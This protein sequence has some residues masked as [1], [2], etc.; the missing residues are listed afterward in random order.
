MDQIPRAIKKRADLN[1]EET[2]R[3]AYMSKR[4]IKISLI[5]F[6]TIYLSAI[7]AAA[8]MQA[9]STEQLTKLSD[10]IIRGEV[11]QVKA[12]WSRDRKTIYTTAVITV[13]EAIKGRNVGKT[14]TA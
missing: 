1:V 3:E 8:L 5:C 9:L 14:V 4:H 12:G 13:R 7:P 10:A 2:G 11:E 6:I